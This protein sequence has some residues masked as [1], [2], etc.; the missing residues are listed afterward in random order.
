MTFFVESHVMPSL[1]YC[2]CTA[3]QYCII[4]AVIHK[5]PWC[6]QI[7]DTLYVDVLH[8]YHVHILS[9]QVHEGKD[10]QRETFQKSCFCLSPPQ[11]STS[12][13]LSKSVP[14][15]ATNT[16]H[17]SFSISALAP[18]ARAGIIDCYRG[19]ED[20]EFN[21]ESLLIKLPLKLHDLFP[22]YDLAA[23]V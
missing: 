9:V 18:S 11:I 14:P 22:A 2:E 10:G 7:M 13:C 20:L 16:P 23:C 3:F 8:H 6:K 17:I 21:S 12:R 5:R 1:S 15:N 4:D 19:S